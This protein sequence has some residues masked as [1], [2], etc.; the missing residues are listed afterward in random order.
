MDTFFVRKQVVVGAVV[1]GFLELGVV[2]LRAF[3]H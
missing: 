3:A 1:F 2:L